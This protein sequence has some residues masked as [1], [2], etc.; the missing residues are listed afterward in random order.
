MLSSEEVKFAYQLILRRPPESEAVLQMRRGEKSVESLAEALMQTAEFR[1][2]AAF[3]KD[4]AQDSKWVCASI[5]KSLRIWLDLNDYGVAAGVLEDNWEPDETNF[6][7][8]N[9]EKGDLFVDVGANIGWFTILACDRVSDSGRVIA[10]EARPDLAD[11]LNLSVQENGFASRC[12]V[13]AVALGDSK[14]QIQIASVP[15]E[16]NPGHSFILK[17]EAESG[18]RVHGSVPMD[19]LDSFNYDR[20][21]KVL[22][23]DV[24][25]AE[26]LVL[27]GA[28]KTIAS[29]KPII[30]MELF[31]KWLK[32][33][34]GVEPQITLELLSGLGYRAFFLTKQGIGREVH[35]LRRDFLDEEYFNLVFISPDR[36]SLLLD[37][38][39]D[40]RVRDLEVDVVRASAE[41]D[42]LRQEIAG[43]KTLLERMQ[44]EGAHRNALQKRLQAAEQSSEAQL[45]AQSDQFAAEKNKLSENIAAL[46]AELNAIR[47]S[48]AWRM[49]S[50]VRRI[51]SKLPASLRRRLRQGLKLA[52]WGAT[53]QLGKRIRERRGLGSTFNEPGSAGH[54][55]SSRASTESASIVSKLRL[56]GPIALIVD[57]RWPQPD[58]DGGSIDAINLIN[59]LAAEGYSICFCTTSEHG[60]DSPYKRSLLSRGI[61]CI[62]PT[63]CAGAQ[64][65]IEIMGSHLSVVFLTRVGAG[66]QYLELLRYNA[67]QAKAIFNT[68][69]LHYLRELRQA[70]VSNDTPAKLSAERTKA[71]ELFLVANSDATI[72]VSE[73]EKKILIEQLPVAN[74]Y[75]IP[76]GR[77][78]DRL[79]IPFSERR[80]IGFIGGFAHQPNVDAVSY[81]LSEIWP[82][83]LSKLPDVEF[84][85]V[86][87][88]LDE[89]ILH[90]APNVK[91]LGFQ[92]DVAPWFNSLRLT[93][94]P[95]RYGAGMKGK[96]I[97]SLAYGV[98]CIGTSVA[99]EGMAVDASSAIVCADTPKAFAE[100]VCEAYLDP[101]IWTARSASGVEYAKTQ[102]SVEAFNKRIHMLLT[103]LELP[104][105]AILS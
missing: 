12:I 93:V 31:P 67:P 15:A 82:L 105:S 5:R 50:P 73:A 99:F 2:L 36:A 45:Q 20:P 7:L 70:E 95:L 64:S 87:A 92:Q 79:E 83:I 24:E 65:F 103:E 91:Y 9:L 61:N 59:A 23:V 88:G 4:G 28:L 53:F 81:F 39:Q 96:V 22:K 51:G 85:I 1:R 18:S 100:A 17:G 54:A 84:T 48:T 69:D 63:I 32:K 101:E 21:I 11:R 60:L 43:L 90:G 76:L 55:A 27:K 102:N 58:R 56:T 97:S 34:S 86:G 3:K 77:K 104:T 6:I 19:M 13:H 49:T 98:P 75:D 30:V 16:H 72:V 41:M 10:F 57:D 33:V 44:A 78:A 25:G 8:S 29:H 89:K 40:D 52:W 42:S 68:V 14:G 66:G 94:A 71:R 38:T 62:D 80:G 46:S 37:T 26:H 47:Q 35:S 74:I